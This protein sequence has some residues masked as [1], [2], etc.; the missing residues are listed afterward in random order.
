MLY[1]KP[2]F[3]FWRSLNLNSNF[4][5]DSPSPTLIS[6][7]FKFADCYRLH[8]HCV[9]SLLDNFPDDAHDK[10]SHSIAMVQIHRSK[11]TGVSFVWLRVLPSRRI[12]VTYFGC[13]VA[14]DLHAHSVLE[15][16][17]VHVT[18]VSTPKRF[19]GTLA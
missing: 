10:A 18:S 7:N 3:K 1:Y 5:A 9:F 4:A 8:L 17:N 14:L 19:L 11:G 2:I 16:R 15:P 13:Y 12:E 6:S